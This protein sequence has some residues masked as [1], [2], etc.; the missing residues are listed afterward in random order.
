[1]ND[2]TG[3]IFTSNQTGPIRVISAD[4]IEVF[5]EPWTSMGWY[6]A[7]TKSAIFGRF[8]ADYFRENFVIL[9]DDSLHSNENINR[10]YPHLPLRIL[11][12]PNLFWSEVSFNSIEDFRDFCTRQNI[13]IDDSIVLNTQE[14]YINPISPLGRTNNGPLIQSIRN[15]GFTGEELLFHAF[16][17]QAQYVKPE[18]TTIQYEKYGPIHSG[19][20][21]YR[22]G[23]RSNKPTYYIAAYHDKAENTL[24]AEK[25]DA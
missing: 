13:Q 5:Y 19:V 9:L 12:Y 16:T 7:N 15:D 3:R 24:R 25:M 1:M 23:I 4:A 17:I 11:R 20:G 14:V 10:F 2:L 21:L 18:Q 8:P 22:S 6:Y